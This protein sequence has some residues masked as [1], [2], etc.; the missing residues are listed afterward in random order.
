MRVYVQKAALGLLVL[1]CVYTLAAA[2]HLIIGLDRGAVALANWEARLE[3]ARR[4]LPV[5]RGVIGYVTE[6]DVPGMS[7]DARDLESEYLLA[8]YA[9]APLI[10][11]KG[12]Q[13]EWNVAVLSPEA[14][15]IW[16][17]SEAGQFQL[18]HLNHNIY[19]LHRMEN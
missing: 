18:I 8:Q 15:R 17:E 1:F 5:E 7:Y 16:R 11:V 19:L 6:W 10:L 14:A 2:L 9:L 12:P 4:N 3:P 13:A